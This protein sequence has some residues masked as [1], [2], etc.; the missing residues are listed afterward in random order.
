MFW[1]L[2]ALILFGDGSCED[3]GASS[4]GNEAG[5]VICEDRCQSLRSGRNVCNK[6]CENL[7]NKKWSVKVNGLVKFT[8]PHILLDITP[9]LASNHSPELFDESLCAF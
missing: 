4:S 6:H 1:L 5:K 7:K 9:G 2:A 3:A 8:V